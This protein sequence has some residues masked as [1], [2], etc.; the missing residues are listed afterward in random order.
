[1]DSSLGYAGVGLNIPERTKLEI[2]MA[3]TQT[4]EKL[5]EISFGA[6]STEPRLIIS[7]AVVRKRH[8]LQ[9]L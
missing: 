1:M 3:K 9:L 4:E 7:S 2:L 5:S 6:K 8:S